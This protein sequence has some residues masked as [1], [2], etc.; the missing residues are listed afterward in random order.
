MKKFI[1]L[2]GLVSIVFL[3]GCA[4]APVG[5]KKRPF[6]MYF[7]PSVDAE[8][9]AN[10]TKGMTSYVSK[11]VSQKLYGK[12][13]GF[14]VK[15]AIPASYI[16]VVEAFGTKKAD[17]AAFSTFAYILTKDIKNYDVEAVLTIVR[18]TD[19][20]YKSQIIA[21]TDAGIN[22]LADLKGKKFAFTDPASTSGY[23]LPSRL[24]KN[25]GIKLGETVFA[26]KHDNVVTMIY[27]GQVDAGATYYSPPTIK[28]E[29]GK[30]VTKIMDARARVK[31]QFPDVE[32]KIKII[33]F[34]RDIP[35]EPWVLRGSLL[36]DPT[37]NAELKKH[38][39]DALLAYAKTPSGKKLI[40]TL[41]TGTGV[42][43]VNESIYDDIR[44]IVLDTDMDIEGMVRK[45]G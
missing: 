33:G 8:E 4:D 30:K 9:I 20:T 14:Y 45:K 2:I 26:Q 36:K 23:I 21:R 24:I 7:I 27:Q 38:V 42:I 19:T 37:K 29:N 31:T 32:E 28:I 1:G 10:T 43:P 39:V 12:D 40:H 3:T 25:K 11:Y 41:A 13:K 17:F 6:T 5:S 35:N 18:G 44:E 22:T 15:G 34:S 16:A